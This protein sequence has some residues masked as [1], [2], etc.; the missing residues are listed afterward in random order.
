MLNL[1]RRFPL[2]IALG[3]F[4]FYGLAASHGVTSNSLVLT[5]KVAGWDWTPIVGH[6]LLWLLTLPLRLLPAGWVALVLN[7]FSAGLAAVTLGLLVRSIELLPWDRPMEIESRWLNAL[8]SLLACS[9][10]GLEFSFWQE[11]TAATGELLDLLLL[12]TPLW[13]LLEYCVRRESRWRNVAVFVWGLGMAEN[14]VMLLTLPL[15]VAGLIWLQG[16]HFFR[17]KLIL[18]LAVLGLAGFSIY[19]LLPL[20]NGL[21]PHSP[22]NL[23]Q[24]WFTS[25]QQTKGLAL[26]LYHQFWRAHRLLTLAAALYFLVPTLSLLVRLRD[27]GTQNKSGVD[28]FQIWLYRALRAVLLLACVWLAFDP[29]M[30]LR[31]II[32]QQFGLSLPLLTL[33]YL[34]ALGAAFLAGNLLLISQKPA[35]LRRRSRAG[36]QWRQLAFPFAAA[37]LSLITIG[38]AVRNAPAIFSENFHPLQRFGELAVASLPAGR[39]VMLSD[40]PQKLAVFQAALSHDRHGRDWLA[41]D[42]HALPTVEYR[43]WLERRRPAGWLTDETR[44]QLTPVETARLLEQAARTNRLFCLHPSHGIFFEQFYLE[45]VDSI[46]EMKLRTGTFPGTAPLS[47]AAT[48]AN[49]NFWTGLWQK[50]LAP[51]ASAPGRR[52]T[53]WLEKIQQLGFTSAPRFQN[54]LLAEWYSL[55]LDGWGVALQQQGRLPEARARFEQALQLNTN[56]F[57]AKINL[58]SNA[59]LQAGRKSG[60]AEAGQMADPPESLQH[61]ILFINHDGPVDDPVYC[62]RLGS[63]FQQSGLPLQAVEQWERTR[64]LAPDAFQPEFALAELYTRL[65]LPDRAR[66]LVEAQLARTPDDVH[67]L[68]LQAAILIQSGQAAAAIPIFDH[69]LSLTNLMAARL[70]RAN[71]QVICQN[72]AAAETDYRELEKSGAEPGRVSYGL[73]AIAEHRHDTNEAVRRLRFCLTNTPSGTLLWRQAGIRLQ[74]LESGPVAK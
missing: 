70:N 74:A 39:G 57:S 12:A 37:S 61:L 56:N 73:A 1:T 31:Q 19:I 68:N 44:H 55:L 26:L 14:W 40:Q 35:S 64:T 41:V 2:L 34:N 51:L 13:L 15:L 20:V 28:R 10:C 48:A 16:R 72:F 25:L 60:L 11:A 53:G 46:Y 22:W 63:L 50:E 59:S 9:L 69:I 49:E 45:P 6:P 18:R 58:A 17:V 38:L 30:G 52:Q 47:V 7:L 67:I 66:Q 36:F 32:Q 5:A 43:A 42:A 65:Q 23:S 24:A 33:D 29:A 54:R 4:V 21:A 27:E 62:F 8:P 71:A 3:A